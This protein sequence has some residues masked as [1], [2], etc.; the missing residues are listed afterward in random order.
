MVAFVTLGLTRSTLYFAESIE[1]TGCRCAC[2][3]AVDTIRRTASCSNFDMVTLREG[4]NFQPTSSRA[5]RRVAPMA[6]TITTM[7]H[8]YS[9]SGVRCGV[10]GQIL[11]GAK[12]VRVHRARCDPKFARSDPKFAIGQLADFVGRDNEMIMSLDHLHRCVGRLETARLAISR[13]TDVEHR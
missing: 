7:T 2:N 5:R 11:R 13:Q 8:Q 9:E 10:R 3:A 4:V 12:R 1:G 6:T